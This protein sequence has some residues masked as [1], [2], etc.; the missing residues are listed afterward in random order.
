MHVNVE[1]EE[2]KPRFRLQARGEGWGICSYNTEG[3]E[4]DGKYA[5]IGM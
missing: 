5:Y 2:H 4:R 3:E 1:S